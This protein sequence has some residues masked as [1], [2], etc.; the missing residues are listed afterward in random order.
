MKPLI[1]ADVL[2]YEIGAIC[3][4]DDGP[5]HFDHVARTID[6]K[7]QEICL[8]ARGDEPPTLYL[9]GEGNFR[10]KIAVTKPY[11]GNRK[12]EKPY[13]F[14]NITTYMVGNY[15]TV[16]VEGMEADD[17]MSIR[18]T[19]E[20]D[21]VICTRD[22]DLRMVPGWHYGWECGAQREYEL[23]EVREPGWLP[24]RS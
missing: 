23:R 6:Q 1:D 11:K 19:R 4:G 17:A 5:L 13:H 20:G 16:I 18:Q 3:E 12:G 10:E 7:I 14:D 8:S 15:D 9:T 21:T 24:L 22:K 2:R